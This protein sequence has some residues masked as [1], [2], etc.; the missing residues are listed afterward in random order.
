MPKF[1]TVLCSTP[2]WDISGDL[3]QVFDISFGKS[4]DTIPYI[5]GIQCTTIWRVNATINIYYPMNITKNGFK[6][7]IS[8]KDEN[9]KNNLSIYSL[10]VIVAY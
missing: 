1:E 10:K 6:I 3:E 2:E 4:F 5:I 8:V 7:R 9:V